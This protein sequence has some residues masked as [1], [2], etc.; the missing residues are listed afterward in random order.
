MSTV[1]VKYLLSDAGQ[2]R[3]AVETGDEPTREQS[4]VIDLAPLTP[5]QRGVLL[6]AREYG[7]VGIYRIEPMSYA[8]QESHYK[9]LAVFDSILTLDEVLAYLAT[10]PTQRAEADRIQAGLRAKSNAEYIALCRAYIAGSTAYIPNT[11]AVWPDV[12]G[13]SELRE[14]V[15]QVEVI[16][17]NLRAAKH[18]A[19]LKWAEQHG[20][21]HLIRSLKSGYDS[22]RL[23]YDERAAV[24]YPGYVYDHGDVADWR[25]RATP[26]LAALDELEAVKAAHEDIT[27]AK[28]V[29]LTTGPAGTDDEYGDFEPCEAVVVDSPDFGEWLVKII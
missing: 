12:D 17:A 28:I 2:R 14:L 20:S 22:T 27:E 10:L 21:E 13:A 23:Y 25:A 8:T 16:R 3:I 4:L 15:V 18:A 5:E 19:R 7:G 1:T 11:I 24:E 6:A 9:G 26:S 29:W